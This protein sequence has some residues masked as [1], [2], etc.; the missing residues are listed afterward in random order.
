M[1]IH[2]ITE[3]YVS[4]ARLAI[5]FLARSLVDGILFKQALREMEFIAEPERLRDLKPFCALLSSYSIF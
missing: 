2:R 3:G 5:P 4:F 1:L